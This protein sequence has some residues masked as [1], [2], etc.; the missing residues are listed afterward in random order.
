MFILWGLYFCFREE[1]E[2]F[3]LVFSILGGGGGRVLVVI[4]VLKGV[5]E[6]GEGG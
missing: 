1:E 6:G 3:G 4:S 2:S 5:F